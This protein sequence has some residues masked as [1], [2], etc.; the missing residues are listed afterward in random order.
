MRNFQI[1]KKKINNYQMSWAII[2]SK[3]NKL[4][5]VVHLVT[6]PSLDLGCV[7]F[8]NWRKILDFT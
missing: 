2:G 4:V 3:T 5:F 7:I 1:D 8:S 6:G